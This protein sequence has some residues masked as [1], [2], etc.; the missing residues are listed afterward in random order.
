[1]NSEGVV[2]ISELMTPEH[3]NLIGKVFGGYVMGLIDK[4]AY[5]CAARHSGKICVTASFDRVDF[6]SPIDVGDLLHLTAHL[7]YVGSTSMGIGVEVHSEN[8]QTGEVRHT[9]SSYVTMVALTEGKPAPVPPLRCETDEDKRRLLLGRYRKQRR[10]ENQEELARVAG[11][12]EKTEGK[13]LDEFLAAK[14]IR[15]WLP[16]E[17]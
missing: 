8:V 6:L 12:L 2:R 10:L 16:E 13:R 17:H 1:M 7:D 11:V 14:S 9:N 15:D 5:V 3:A 4:A